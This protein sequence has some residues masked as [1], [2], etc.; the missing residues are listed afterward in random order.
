MQQPN[1]MRLWLAENR[2]VAIE[3]L[4]IYLGIVLLIKGIQFVADKERAAEYLAMVSLPFFQF[5]SMH[6]VALVHIAGGLL[7]AIG[8]FSRVAALIQLPIILGAIFFVHF[9][10]GLFSKEQSL[11]FAI[12]VFVLL[13][14]FTIYG[15]G[16]L[17]VDY[18]LM[19]RRT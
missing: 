5:L 2:E 10:Q 1:G 8:L 7:L 19:H 4:R 17:S 9:D 11:E 6:L 3:I 13:L 18:L 14:T 12:L 15:S 16:R